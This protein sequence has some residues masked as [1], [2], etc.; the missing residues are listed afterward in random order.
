MEENEENLSEGKEQ[1]GPQMAM[2]RLRH[3][4]LREQSEA[5]HGDEEASGRALCVDRKVRN[6]LILKK[7]KPFEKQFIKH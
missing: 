7:R 6:D 4:G 2:S 5:T 1:T 3:H